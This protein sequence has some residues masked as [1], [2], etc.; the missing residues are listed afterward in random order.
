MADFLT[1]AEIYGAV[2]RACKKTGTSDDTMVKEMVNMV[3]YEMLNADDL[4]PLYWL[5]DFD[6]TLACVAPTTITAITQADPGVITVSA[7]HGLTANVDIVSVFNIVGMTTLN[8]RMYL[9]NTTPT[10]TSLSL[11]D[12][13]K[14]DAID[15]SGLTAW[16]SGGT[17][18]HAGKVLGTTGKN[19][20]RIISAEWHD[21]NSMVE[22]TPEEL[23]KNPS[24]FGDS[25]AQPSR[26]YLRKKYTLLGVENNQLLWFY[27]TDQAYDLRYWF[28]GRGAKLSGDTDVPL[29]PPQCHYGIV[30]GAVLRLYQSGVQID[31]E[32]VWPGIY[33][34][35]LSSLLT[36]NRKSWQDHDASSRIPPFLL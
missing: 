31:S 16:S 36:F 15:T 17:V 14:V 29:L 23:S 11:I 1:F 2:K 33:K 22:I 32:V 8:N 27:P 20:Q 7:A 24:Y 35:A 13:D 18:H 3:Y 19:V 10:T 4:Y 6:D 12:L 9:V 26:Y 28:E 34:L 5:S 30:A 21:E 25:T